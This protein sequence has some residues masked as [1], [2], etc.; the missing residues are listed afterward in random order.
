MKDFSKIKEKGVADCAPEKEPLK[1]L[2]LFGGIGAPR[3]ALSIAGYKIKSID[4]V[5]VLPYAVLAYNHIF[6]CGYDPQDIRIWNMN[7][8][9]V[10]HGSPCQDWSNEGKNDVNTGRSILYERTL[11]ILDPHPASGDRVL[12][13]APNVVLWENV[14]GLLYRHKEHLDSYI[15]TMNGYGYETKYAVL[16]ASDY[17]IP[18]DRPRLYTVSVM[19]SDTPFKFPD[20]VKPTWQLK[21]FIDTSVDFDA[22]PLSE[23]EK[24]IFFEKDGRLYV[25]EATKTGYKEVKE[26]QVVNVAFPNSKT[27]R[28]R[29]GDVAKTITTSPR[30]A[31]YYNGRLRLLTA[32]EYMRLMG[33]RDRDYDKMVRAGITDRQISALAGN[34][35][36]VPVLVQIF[37][38][39]AA[40]GAMRKP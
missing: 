20:P 35:I 8:D 17:N 28:G 11:Q 7:P 9:I 6:D 36:C 24:E 3:R 4:Y 15:E 39:L 33:Y 30:Q 2:E 10:V 18:Q 5:E 13:S 40:C 1:I 16:S 12:P 22:Y 32:K 38:E 31:V 29:V 27:R 25:R 14:P 26:W 21:Q 19:K 37:K 34:S 23:A